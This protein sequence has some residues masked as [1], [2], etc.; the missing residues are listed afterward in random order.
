[1]TTRRRFTRFAVVG[2]SLVA[3]ALAGCTRMNAP[4]NR[5]TLSSTLRASNEIPD[6]AS[7]GSGTV[8]AV[9]NTDTNMLSWKLAHNGLTGP[10]TMGHFHGPALVS[11]N[12]GVALAWASADNGSEGNATL[13]PAQAADLLAGR[14]YA[15][16]HTK[17]NP[18][19]E[20][21]GQMSVRN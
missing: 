13:T 16:V 17:A 12:A 11:A 5:V 4:T 1:M 8:D 20:I 18:G 15:N 7:T 9:L 3:A 21:R 19:G 10:A 2:L 14:W 6:N